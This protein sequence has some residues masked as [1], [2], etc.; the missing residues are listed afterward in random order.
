MVFLSPDH[1]SVLVDEVLHSIFFLGK[2][3]SPPCLPHVIV[4]DREMLEELQNLYP[5]PFVF[6]FTQLPKRSPFS[7]VLDMIIH[8]TGQKV[9]LTEEAKESDIIE[10]LREVISDLKKDK[11][12]DLISSAICVSQ[13]KPI[14]DSVRYYGVSMST[15][16]CVPGR[17]MVAASCL[18]TWDP[19]VAD[20]VM[21]YNPDKVKKDY[22]DGTFQIQELIR[23]QAFSLTKGGQM[24]PCRSCGNLFGLTTCQ[25][26]VWAYGN[27]AEA[28]SISNLLKNEAEVR[29]QIRPTS[30]RNTERNRQRAKES[31]VNDLKTWLKLV[32]FNQQDLQFYTPELTGGLKNAPCVCGLF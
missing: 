17:I 20:A 14:Q 22:F 4:N 13:K 6:Y 2:I 28:E 21:T 32:K 27:C 15:S 24:D 7:C 3:H 12:N 26:K 9:F 29:E 18:S 30:D 5:Q 16:G 10:S 8:L 1:P 23:C 31:V 25:I 11:A 19:F